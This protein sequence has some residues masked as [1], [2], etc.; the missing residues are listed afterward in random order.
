M[1]TYTELSHFPSSL[2][3]LF[4]AVCLHTVNKFYVSKTSK[5]NRADSGGD[6]FHA[7][8]H[9]ATPTLCKQ[10]GVP[11]KQIFTMQFEEEILPFQ[12][13]SVCPSVLVKD[14]MI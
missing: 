8:E 3:S 7:S 10:T 11:W 6:M 14:A 12:Y 13:K 1:K 2:Y 9:G 4:M 5:S